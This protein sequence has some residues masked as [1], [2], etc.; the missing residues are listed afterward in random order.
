MIDDAIISRKHGERTFDD[1]FAS[2]G[3]FST[4]A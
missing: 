2:I 4:D 1:D 3:A